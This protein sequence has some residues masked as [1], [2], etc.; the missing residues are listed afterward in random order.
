MI[1]NIGKHFH[2]HPIFI[3]PTKFELLAEKVRRVLKKRRWV[4]DP[5]MTPVS[6]ICHWFS[7]KQKRNID[8]TDASLLKLIKKYY[9]LTLIVRIQEGSFRR[10]E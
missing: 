6:T 9:Y 5:V 10:F 7:K 2:S 3:S 8:N 4:A 1:D